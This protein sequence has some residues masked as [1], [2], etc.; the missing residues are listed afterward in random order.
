MR[1]VLAALLLLA[2]CKEDPWSQAKRDRE[3]AIEQQLRAEKERGEAK[4]KAER[5]AREEAMKRIDRD[6][7]TGPTHGPDSKGKKPGRPAN[8]PPDNPLCS[9]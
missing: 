1:L 5:E 4:M 7:G 9:P 6:G 8:C 3:E 2:A